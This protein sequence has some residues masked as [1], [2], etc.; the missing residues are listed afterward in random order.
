MYVLWKKF[1]EIMLKHINIKPC[2]KGFMVDNP[3][4]NYNVVKIIYGTRNSTMKMVHKERTY[5]FQ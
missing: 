3:Q 4:A 2:F 1:N 5:F